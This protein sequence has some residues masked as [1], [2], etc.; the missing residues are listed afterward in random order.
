MSIRAGAPDKVGCGDV[1]EIEERRAEVKWSR[2]MAGSVGMTTKTHD[3]DT[4]SCPARYYGE[5]ADGV[6]LSVCMHHRKV[7]R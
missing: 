4:C 5:V 7:L 2:E 1:F 6:Y 3:R